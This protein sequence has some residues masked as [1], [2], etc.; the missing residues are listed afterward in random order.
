MHLCLYRVQLD[1]NNK[2]GFEKHSNMVGVIHS[3][4]KRL[5][6]LAIQ[7]SSQDDSWDFFDKF[8]EM[9]ERVGETPG[10]NFLLYF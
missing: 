2:R 4:Y 7:S 9:I 8:S 6:K 10:D 5:E 1:G 3:A